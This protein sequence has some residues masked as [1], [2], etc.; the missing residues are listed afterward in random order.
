MRRQEILLRD[1]NTPRLAV[2]LDE[3]A[4]VR[5]C[6]GFEIMTAQL[7]YLRELIVN[8]KSNVTIELLPFAAGLHGI[9]QGDVTILAIPGAPDTVYIEGP[10]VPVFEDREMVVSHYLAQFN[11]AQKFTISGNS[12]VKR[13]DEVILGFSERRIAIHLSG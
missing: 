1:E 4:I 11:A 7:Q 13:L 10:Q 2:I 6:G 3:S 12:L 9:L 8:P 5:C